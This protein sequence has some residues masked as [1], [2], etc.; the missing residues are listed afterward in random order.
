MIRMKIA[1]MQRR[2]LN[3]SALALAMVAGLCGAYPAVASA[4]SF[5]H[6]SGAVFVARENPARMM[7]VT[8]VLRL[9]DAQTAA[10]FALA[11]STPGDT[12][13]EH[14][15]T[16]AQFRKRFGAPADADSRIRS[17]AKANGLIAEAA[18]GAG[19]I[20][21]VRGTIAAIEKA[22]GL[23]INLYRAPDG[24]M[25]TSS[26]SAPLL[27]PAIAGDVA[28]ITGLDGY[29][30]FAPLVRRAPGGLRADG[31]GPLAGGGTG[32][33]GTFAP[34]DL[35]TA[36]GIPAPLARSQKQTVAIFEQG[37]FDM[38]DVTAYETRFHIPPNTITVLNVGGYGGG[39]NDP[40]VAL[41]AVLDID[42]VRATNPRA[43]IVMVQDGAG[44]TFGDD[45]VA[46]LAAI[47]DDGSAQTVSISYG[48]DEA[49]GDPEAQLLIELAAQGQATFASAGDN[50]AYGDGSTTTYA[51]LHPASNPFITSVGGT[52]LYTFGDGSWADEEAW[53]LLTAGYGATGGGISTVWPIPAWQLAGGQSVA[54]ANG[55]SSTMRNVP[56]V[57]AVGNPLTGVAVYDGQLG[58]WLQVGG[59]SVAAPIW[60]GFYSLLNA[61]HRQIGLGA[62]GFLA[63]ALYAD[64]IAYPEYDTHDILSGTNG[65]PSNQGFA[66]GYR[67][68]NVSG[69]GSMIGPKLLYAF[70]SNPV[71]TRVA[72]PPAVRDVQGT[73][74]AT[75]ARFSWKG[76]AA[77]T[78][79][80]LEEQVYDPNGNPTVIT[81]A[82]VAITTGTTLSMDHLQ[83]ATTYVFRVNAVNR[84]GEIFG[85]ITIL[86]TSQ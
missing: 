62:L 63:P 17:W 47:A 44:D 9:Q 77:A 28:A 71:D 20:L 4:K 49:D 78:G 65:N 80:I 48:E 72:K 26:A 70:L 10:Q 14:F 66:A 43:D 39:I 18:T 34:A 55:G 23:T 13:Y 5:G 22:F 41:E 59:T 36:Y 64:E 45:L 40:N 11:V 46:A 53:N 56:D 83:P 25:F 12:L 51:V 60:A 30:Q 2:T 15:L 52:T 32:P 38:G 3:R 35:R 79:Y 54:T 86:T 75:S 16:P 33:G 69:W 8:L 1:T 74:A 67:Y 29:V 21:P 6:L 61:A 50:G 42:M 76:S 19:T 73:A 85:P 24:H 68:D 58:G 27:P 81:P 7:S 37:G 82:R 31:A 57:T 84:G